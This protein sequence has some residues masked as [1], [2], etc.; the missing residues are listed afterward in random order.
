M[1]V[2]MI[3]ARSV[4]R[5]TSALQSRALGMTW[6]HSEKGRLVVRIVPRQR[7]LDKKA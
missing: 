5:S 1:P 3:W 4:V 7:K 6:V 2:S